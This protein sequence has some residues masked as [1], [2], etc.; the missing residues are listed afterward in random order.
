MQAARGDF[1]C[2]P[3][4]MP[5]EESSIHCSD[6]HELSFASS[7]QLQFACSRHHLPTVKPF[8]CPCSS[9]EQIRVPPPVFV[10]TP[11]V[12]P[13]SRLRPQV[14]NVCPSQTSQTLHWPFTL[15]M[16]T[17]I[18]RYQIS[19]SLCTCRTKHGHVPHFAHAEEMY[20]LAVNHIMYML[21]TLPQ[22]NSPASASNSVAGQGIKQTHLVGWP[23][24]PFMGPKLPCVVHV[25]SWQ[26]I[27]NHSLCMR[28]ILL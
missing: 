11:V 6:Q 18:C 25:N 3:C 7:R 13:M 10:Y 4:I 26:S 24:L 27:L 8:S 19:H 16:L 5:Q 15:H 12:S 1:P 28:A 20:S 2:I 14:C 23:S 22:T 9:L 17:C 21:K